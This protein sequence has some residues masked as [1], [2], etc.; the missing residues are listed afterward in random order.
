MS[1]APCVWIVDDDA[2]DQFLFEVALKQ[3]SPQVLVRPLYD[4]EELL[5]ALQ[6]SPV[7]PTLILLDLNMPR[8]NGFET[9]QQLRS[10]TAFA[11]IPVVVLTTST[12]DE[13]KEMAFQLGANGFLT[14][15]PSFERTLALFNQ[16][17]AQWLG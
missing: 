9:L 17:A 16:L 6:K 11:S 2:D 5:P 7:L 14:K 13:D 8:L 4:G 3:L 10:Q 1:I 12:Q 15:P